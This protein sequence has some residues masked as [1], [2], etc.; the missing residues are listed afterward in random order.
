ML[1]KNAITKRRGLQLRRD[2][3]VCDDKNER[4]YI[5]GVSFNN[6]KHVR[7]VLDILSLGFS[8]EITR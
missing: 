2:V 8:I 5:N 7:A 1:N 3:M 4:E 6:A